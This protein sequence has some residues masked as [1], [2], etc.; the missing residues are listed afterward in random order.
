MRLNLNAFIAPLRK[1]NP[2]K[3][4]LFGSHAYG[5]PRNDSDVDILVILNTNRSF[6]QRIQEIRPLLP[7]G[8]A[9]D[10]IVLTPK[11]YQQSKITNPLISEI[12]SK[13]KIIYG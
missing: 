5:T 11:E 8:R 6:H 4:I 7:K 12:D 1:I 10:L 3:I 9:I 2:D 13:G